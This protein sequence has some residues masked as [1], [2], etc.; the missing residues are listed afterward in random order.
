MPIPTRLVRLLL[1]CALLSCTLGVPATASAQL[2]TSRGLFVTGATSADST[3]TV[4][5]RADM[6]ASIDMSTRRESRFQSSSYRAG[7]QVDAIRFG[8]A[9]SLG[10][11]VGGELQATPDN[12]IGFDPHGVIW[13]EALMLS[14]RSARWLRGGTWTFGGFLRCRHD[15]DNGT[16]ARA[17]DTAQFVFAN[18][19][20]VV[21]QGFNG[22]IAGTLLKTGR[23]DVRAGTALDLYSRRED[24]RTP[25]NTVAPDWAQARG[26]LELTLRASVA[27]SARSAAYLRAWQ[28]TVHFKG[29]GDHMLTNARG[30]LGV[31]FLGPA[32]GIDLLVARERTFDDA[33]FAV[34]RAAT[35]TTIGLR[36]SG[37]NLF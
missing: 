2:S 10:V 19:R 35:F 26:A 11:L 16:P 15:V 29:T 13:E 22:G 6:F 1:C 37:S 34:P 36:L 5:S 9:V 12:N 14:G 24:R 31:R 23:F 8:R 3:P 25:R 27:T 33:M 28:S 30:E 21:L 20:T 32:G 4:F 7:A 17:R 18:G